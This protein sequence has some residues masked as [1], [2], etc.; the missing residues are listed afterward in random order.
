MRTI[1][2]GCTDRGVGQQLNHLSAGA[3]SRNGRPSPRREWLDTVLVDPEESVEVAF[4]ADN[5]GDWL[6]H[7]HML[8]H[9]EAGMYA[10]LR[11]A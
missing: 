3:A 6:F 9:M 4:V 5:P 1:A 11:I 7:C 8:E 10:T 2:V